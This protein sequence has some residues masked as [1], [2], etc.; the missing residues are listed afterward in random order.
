MPSHIGDTIR[1]APGGRPLIGS[2]AI[3]LMAAV[4]LLAGHRLPRSVSG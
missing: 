3:A 2:I 1:L 4:G